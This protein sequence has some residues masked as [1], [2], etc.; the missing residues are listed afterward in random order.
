MIFENLRGSCVL[1]V[2]DDC[3]HS[4]DIADVMRTH[5]S[6][7]I[8][9]FTDYESILRLLGDGAVDLALIELGSDERTL[10]YDVADRLVEGGIPFLFVTSS[11]LPELPDRFHG[12]R[13][14]LET[15]DPATVPVALAIEN[16][17]RFSSR[18]MNH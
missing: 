14:F 18:P 8:G 2:G 10:A 17:K 12:V 7:V 9:P 15:G 16:A 1:L 13:C 6:K 11:D 4:S 5:E 3:L